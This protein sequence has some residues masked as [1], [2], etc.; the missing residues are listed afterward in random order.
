MIARLMRLLKRRRFVDSASYWEYRYRSGGNSGPGSYS[1]LAEFKAEIL[2]AF[3]EQHDIAT[4]VEFGCGDGNQLSLANYPNYVGYDVSDRA[5]NLCRAR[6]SGDTTKTFRLVSQYD[7]TKSDLALS[8][9]VIFHLVEDDIFD[10]YMRRLFDS[11]SRFVGVYS[12]N[13]ERPQS[14][15]S[16]HVRHRRF[17]GWIETHAPEWRLM[18][19][20]PNRYPD[21]GDN[22]TSSFAD[23][24]FYRRAST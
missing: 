8:L 13:D 15:D 3:V 4:V 19:Q 2:N 16:P 6:F 17:S 9:D 24:Y 10:D 5:V 12:S 11:S 1:R 7:G 14:K 20:V 23:F 18:K 21:D 22:R